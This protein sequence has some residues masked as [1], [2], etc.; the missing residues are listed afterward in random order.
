MGNSRDRPDASQDAFLPR[1]AVPKRTDAEL[2]TAGREQDGTS[3]SRPRPRVLDAQTRAL[4]KGG[5]LCSLIAH[6]LERDRAIAA[7]RRFV[8][9]NTNAGRWRL[10][11]DGTALL[12][13]FEQPVR[14]GDASECDQV[15]CRLL[16]VADKFRE[17]IPQ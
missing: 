12:D 17:T 5:R 16:G 7:H 4:P 9:K 2:T 1:E 3:S 15:E 11:G 6:R 13:H 14:D 8:R 10:V